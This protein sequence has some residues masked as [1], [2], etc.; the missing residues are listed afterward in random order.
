[1][2]AVVRRITTPRLKKLDIHFFNQLTFF[3]QRLQQ[4]MNTTENLRLET[5][6]FN[7]A[8]GQVYVLGYPHEEVDDMHALH[9]SVGCDHL[10]WQVTSAA[11]IF[12]SLS[13]AFTSVEHLAFNHWEHYDSVEEHN[14]VDRTEWRKL[15]GL[16]SN[17]KTFRI[18][19]GLVE[20]LSRSLE[21]EDGELPLEVLPELQELTY[22]AGGKAGD[23][24][25]S[26]IDARQDAG[27]PVTLV[28]A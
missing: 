3:V 26:F 14:E 19:S 7:F 12:N 8:V 22:S 6:E 15:L 18:D 20:E 2:E 23:A 10:D 24:F 11:Q 1:L 21:S 4:F 17:V 27:R 13:Q 9:L 16:F 25:N 28:R 5:A